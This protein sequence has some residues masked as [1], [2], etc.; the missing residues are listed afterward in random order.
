MNYRVDVLRNYVPIGTLPFTSC[1]IKYNADAKIKRGASITTNMEMM[2]LTVSSF[3][4]MSD[5]LSPVIIDD[6]GVEHR[7]GIF[8]L[9]SDP[10]SY[11]TAYDQASLEMYDESYILDQS[12]FDTRHYYAAGTPY[13]DVFS[14]LLTEAGLTRQI[15]DESSSCLSIDREFA[16][17]ENVLETLNL[18]LDEAGYESLHM[19]GDGYARCELKNESYV[20]EFVYRSFENAKI[21]DGVTRTKDIYGIPN[22]FIGVVSNPDQSLMVYTAENH[23]L[24][25]ELSI[26]RRGYKLSKVYKLQSV[27]DQLA[28]ETYVNGLLNDSMI[29]LE[30]VQ[31]NT[32]IEPG[33]DFK[34]VVQV[35]HKDITGLYIEK[36]WSMNL[37]TSQMMNHTLEK[38][39]FI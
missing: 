23:N 34:A 25:S 17:G 28:L 31:L 6:N 35:E 5:R 18:M 1:N 15:I 22:V 38:R 29:A 4:R 32:D 16:V 11:G 9:I 27:A 14:S 39:I 30:T 3:E 19:D 26:E 33:H 20:P 8:M 36:A 2:D 10:I 21:R 12:A 24:N 7:E 37:N 13:T